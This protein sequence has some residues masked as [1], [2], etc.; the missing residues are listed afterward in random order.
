MKTCLRL[1]VIGVAALLLGACSLF[2]NEMIDPE[3]ALVGLR[4]GP[5]DGL[6]QTVIVDLQITNPNGSD[7][8]L[9]AIQ[10][11]IRLDG[12]DLISGSSREPLD[13]EAGGSERYSVPASI[14]LLSGFSFIKDMLT[15]PRDKIAYELNATLEPSGLFSLPITVKKADTIA[16]SR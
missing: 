6:N 13:V 7:L 1:L 8:R 12:R 10:Y 14:S 2:H 16:L 9:N 11:R 15:K 4:A 5:S 3:V